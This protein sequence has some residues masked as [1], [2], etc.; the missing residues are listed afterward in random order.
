MSSLR[1]AIPLPLVFICVSNSFAWQTFLS[2]THKEI[3]S[4]AIAVLPTNQSGNSDYPDAGKYSVAL[5]NGSHTESHNTDDS[6]YGNDNALNGGI[7]YWWWVNA[8]ENKYK[9]WLIYDAYY[10]MGRAY[11]LIQDQGVPAHAANISH[12]SA[13][14]AMEEGPKEHQPIY[15][16]GAVNDYLVPYSFYQPI[17]SNTLSNIE[18]HNWKESVSPFRDYWLTDN[19]DAPEDDALQPPGWGVYGGGVPGGREQLYAWSKNPGIMNLQ[20]SESVNYTAGA[21]MAASKLLPPLVRIPLAISAPVINTETGNI[22]TFKIIENRSPAVNISILIAE[23][24]QKI[25]D[26]SNNLWDQR[27]ETDLNFPNGTEL[28]YEKSFSINWKGKVSGEQLP[29]GNYTLQIF[30]QDSDGNIIPVMDNDG[31]GVADNSVDFPVPLTLFSVGHN[32]SYISLTGRPSLALT[33]NAQGADNTRQQA[34]PG[35]SQTP[36]WSI[37]D[38]ARFVN[39]ALV[40]GTAFFSMK[41][42]RP[43][44][45]ERAVISGVWVRFLWLRGCR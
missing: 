4:Q 6:I 11:H 36:N 8:F 28:P 17:L 41:E 19:M 33:L 3:T 10:N 35:S 21:I 39:L 29:D 2:T 15:T 16:F 37:G 14:D 18:N 26:S 5:Q 43:F 20:Y 31:D 22:I 38:A 45:S 32:F 13:I 44:Q 27:S 34:N 42:A 7:P 40:I 1:L 25:I 24:G 12:G 23:T 30:A 9:R